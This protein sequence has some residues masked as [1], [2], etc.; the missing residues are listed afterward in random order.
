MLFFLW[1]SA[2]IYETGLSDKLSTPFLLVLSVALPVLLTALLP[3]ADPP[4]L[5][6]FLAGASFGYILEK[7]KV[8]SLVEAKLILQ[9]IKVVLGAAV[10]FGIIFGLAGVLPSAVTLFGFIRYAL[11]GIWVTLFAPL[12]FVSLKLARRAEN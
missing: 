12:I 6:G 10:L 9:V 11:G 2:K 4:K 5:M 3:G 7:E 1:V 8:R